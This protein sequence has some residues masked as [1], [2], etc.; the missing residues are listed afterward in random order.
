M[1]RSLFKE[2]MTKVERNKQTSRLRYHKE[3][4]KDESKETH[5]IHLHCPKLKIKNIKSSKTKATC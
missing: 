4:Q 2:I 5:K 3:L 1:A